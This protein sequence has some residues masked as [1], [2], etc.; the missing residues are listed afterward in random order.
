MWNGKHSEC[1]LPMAL[2]KNS[3]QVKP[4]HS[5]SLAPHR[6]P[7]E[8]KSGP[9]VLGLGELSRLLPPAL[10]G[11]SLPPSLEKRRKECKDGAEV[12]MTHLTS[13]ERAKTV[14]CL[15]DPL[16]PPPRCQKRKDCSLQPLESVW[17]G[18]LLHFR[19][20]AFRTLRQ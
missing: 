5:P 12:G 8:G 11:F 13:Q 15:P 19:L 16:P 3:I 4:D 20:V 7:L 17:L 9:G 1:S 14:P 18:G 6:T 10:A 2:M